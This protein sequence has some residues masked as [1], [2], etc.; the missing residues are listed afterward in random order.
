MLTSAT[1]LEVS[2][3]VFP[4][5]RIHYLQPSI[6][7]R[8]GQHPAVSSLR[9]MAL[10]VHVCLD[11]DKKTIKR[12]PGAKQTRY[13]VAV[14]EVYKELLQRVRPDVIFFPPGETAEAKILAGVAGELSIEIVGC[15][16]GRHLGGSFFSEDIVESLPSYAVADLNSLEEAHKFLLAFRAGGIPAYN[17]APIADSL[18]E[19]Q[20]EEIRDA[21]SLPSPLARIRNVAWSLVN[22]PEGMSAEGIRVRMM[23]SLPIVSPI[24]RKAVRG[25][26]KAGNV[27]YIASRQI[28]RLPDRFIFFPLQ[29]SPESSINFPAPYF[30]DQLR[31]V[32]AIRHKMP[33]DFLLVVKEHPAA[34]EMRPRS[35]LNELA[36]RSGVVFVGTDWNTREII[37][38]A[39][40]TVSVTGSAA[41]EAFLLGRPS[42]VLGSCFFSG[43]L[44]GVCSMD[45]IGET[46]KEKMAKGVTDDEILNSIAGAFHCIS[47]FLFV[48][49]DYGFGAKY[50]LQNKN[51]IAFM[52]ALKKH[53]AVKGLL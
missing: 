7:Q 27:A 4:S 18:G 16:N 53:L 40:L 32:D 12:W 21:P 14:Y 49:P 52:S 39:S 30:V 19:P 11:A 24:L 25:I 22:E 42:L 26:R 3:R 28:D 41:F 8:M 34:L 17:V 29:Y 9:D 1:H 33:N 5:E 50:V 2:G 44:G 13:G 20:P 37:S 10:S 43:F 31:V 47:R 23:N 36:R 6:K 45:R 35:F 38:R 51:I 48:A 46:M 15:V